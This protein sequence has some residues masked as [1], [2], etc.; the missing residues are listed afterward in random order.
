MAAE[1]IA[2]ECLAGR[3]RLISRTVTH[4]FDDA[5]RPLRMRVSQLNILVFVAKDGP[6]SP[7]DV[8][9]RL[10]IEKSTVSRNV[11]RMLT[12]GWLKKSDSDTG[13][14]QILEISPAGRTLVKKSLPLWR[15]AQA[16]VESLLGQQGTQSIR[17]GAE[18]AQ[19]QHGQG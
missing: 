14:R 10:N 17:R 16:Q 2:S 13:S 19:H 6:V 1:I 12:R 4:I 7:G 3:I 8:A 11:D 15:N 18:H 9:R 5:L